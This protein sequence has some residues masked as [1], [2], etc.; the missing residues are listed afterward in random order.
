MSTFE[1]PAYNG[2]VFRNILVIGVADSYN[3]RAAFEREL[4]QDI[5][6][7]GAEAT[8]LYTVLDKD[9]PINKSTVEKVV[10]EGGFDAILITRALNR[11]FKSKAKGFVRT[12]GFLSSVLPYS[13]ADWEKRSIFLNFLVSKLPSPLLANRKFTLRSLAT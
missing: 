11:D 8:A 6:S 5:K 2:P 3:N 10:D 12:Y 13:N 1:G 9:T 7:G 4:V